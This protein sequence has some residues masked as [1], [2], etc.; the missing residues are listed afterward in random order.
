MMC[1]GHGTFISKEVRKRAA[2]DDE[3]RRRRIEFRIQ[4][5]AAAVSLSFWVVYS[6]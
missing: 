2:G 4:A 6:I 1:D 3:N 5:A